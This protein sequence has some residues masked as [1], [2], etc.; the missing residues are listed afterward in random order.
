MIITSEYLE[1]FAASEVGTYKK[2]PFHGWEM[3]PEASITLDD[4]EH[5]QL[6]YIHWDDSPE[7]KPWKLKKGNENRWT[8]VVVQKNGETVGD[9]FYEFEGLIPPD[10]LRTWFREHLKLKDREPVKE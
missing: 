7:S 3:P 5:H 4:E 10:L 2:I 8:K 1:D 6:A 9:E